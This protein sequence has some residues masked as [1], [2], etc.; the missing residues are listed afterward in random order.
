MHKHYLFLANDLDIPVLKTTRSHV[1]RAMLNTILAGKLEVEA[2]ANW[3]GYTIDVNQSLY[4]NADDPGFLDRAEKAA[5][6]IWQ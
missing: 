3:F 5:A 4:F 6:S 1:R 2:R